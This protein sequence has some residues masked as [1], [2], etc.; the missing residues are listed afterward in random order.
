MIP[1]NIP[2]IVGNEQS[3]IDE[4]FRNQ[5]YCCGNLF[6][7]KCSDWL[8]TIT[9]SKK[10]LVTNSCANALEMAAILINISI[11]DEVI[12]PSF[13]FVSTANA[14]IL[15]GAKVVFVDIRPDTMNIDETKIEAAITDKTKAI[16]PVHYAGVSC[17]MDTIMG[18]A[19]KYNLF[20]VEDAAQA[21]MSRYKGKMLGSIGHIGCYSFHETKNCHCGQGGAIIV[22]DEKFVER[23][24]IIS[25]KGTNRINFLLKKVDKYTWVDIGSCYLS[26]ELNAAFLYAQL[27]MAEQVT[28]KRIALWNLY[29]QNLSD[30]LEIELPTIPKDCAYNGHIFYI[31]L[32]DMEQVSKM[33][34]YLKENDIDSTSHYVPLHSSPFGKMNTKTA[35]SMFYTDNESSRLLRLP[36]YYQLQVEQV[37]Y[38]TKCIK[39]FFIRG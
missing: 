39:G 32:Q 19:K 15:R 20:V 2:L 36:M 17:E 24:Q 25:E 21:I 11:G 5:K 16:V 4:V 26:S 12:M 10:V 33:I 35:G 27:L 7:K 38:I 22:N 9:K 30:V 28:Q 1:F 29:Y 3:N 34:A 6:G 37:E 23:S 13:T 31:K 8:E 14:F 18:I